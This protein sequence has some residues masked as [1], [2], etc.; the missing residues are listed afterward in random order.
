M[1]LAVKSVAVVIRKIYFISKLCV[2]TCVVGIGGGVNDG[3]C[4]FLLAHHQ[5]Q[6]HHQHHLHLHHHLHH[7]LNHQHTLKYITP[8]IIKTV[9]ITM[10]S[11]PTRIIFNN[12]VLL[13]LA[14]LDYFGFLKDSGL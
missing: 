11:K 1:V 6:Q 10:Y 5:Q 7:H 4:G 9:T 2:G 14:D 12:M 13:P 3:C 8:T